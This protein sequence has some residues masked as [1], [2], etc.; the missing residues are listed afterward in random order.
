MVKRVPGMVHHQPFV[1]QYA[2][3]FLEYLAKIAQIEIDAA[4]TL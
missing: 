4:M 1:R 2:K 3:P